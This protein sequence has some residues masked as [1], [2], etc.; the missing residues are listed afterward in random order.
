MSVTKTS[1]GPAW[2]ALYWQYFEELDKRNARR[3]ALSLERQLYRETRTAAGPRLEKLTAATPC[4]WAMPWW[5]A[6]CYAPTAPSNTCTSKTS[7]PPVW[8][9]STS[10]A[11]TSTRTGWAT[12]RAPRRG[13]QLLPE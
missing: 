12:T 1:P 4:A 6:W 2:G 10:S 8:S 9:P 5:C 13:H 11:A 7:A 3:H